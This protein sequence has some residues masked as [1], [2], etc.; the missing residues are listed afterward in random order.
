LKRAVEIGEKYAD[1]EV[2]ERDRSA[3]EAA[4]VEIEEED[5][6]HEFSHYLSCPAEVVAKQYTTY[7]AHSATTLAGW[8]MIDG[9]P[10]LLDTSCDELA[11]EQAEFLRCIFGNPF[12]SVTFDPAWRTSTAVGIADAI[13]ADRAFD[14]LPILADALQDAGCEDAAILDHCRGP[15][16]HVRGCWVV[17]LVLGK[18]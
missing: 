17:D 8:I 13:Y 6:Y 9:E 12:C 16:P 3:A 14:R 10:T 18:E 5:C 1:G 15:G 7:S 11:V 2:N 4:A